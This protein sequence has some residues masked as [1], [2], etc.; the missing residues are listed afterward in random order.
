[1]KKDSFWHKWKGIIFG[2]DRR[3]LA[4]EMPRE[5]S[6]PFCVGELVEERSN[7]KGIGDVSHL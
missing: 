1:L 2:P 7:P 4:E 5:W 3:G 6:K